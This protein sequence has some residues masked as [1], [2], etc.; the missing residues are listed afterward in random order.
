MDKHATTQVLLETVFST[1]SMQRGYKEDNRGNQVS[2]VWEA[3]KKRVSFI[4]ESEEEA[5]RRE[6]LFK[7]DLSCEAEECPLL[8]AIAREQLVKT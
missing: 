6:T 7:D 5:F 8:Q 2:S 4:W 3:V 1:Q